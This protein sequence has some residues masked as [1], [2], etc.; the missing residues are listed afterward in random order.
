MNFIIHSDSNI[1]DSITILRDMVN[2][3]KAPYAKD[4][5]TFL[6]QINKLESTY[7]NCTIHIISDDSA[8]MSDYSKVLKTN[9]IDNILYNLFDKISKMINK[10]SSHGKQLIEKFKKIPK[11]NPNN[12]IQVESKKPH[13]CECCN[14]LME[15]NINTFVRTCNTCGNIED[16]DM[17]IEDH[18]FVVDTQDTTNNADILKEQGEKWLNRIQAREYFKMPIELDKALLREF[19]NQN[20]TDKREINY[21]KIRECLKNIREA[22]VYN[23]NIPSICKYYT[24]IAPEQLTNK[25]RTLIIDIFV[26]WCLLYINKFLPKDKSNV[27][28]NPY[29]L[30]RIIEIVLPSDDPIQRARKRNIL[31]YIHIQRETTTEANDLIFDK[32]AKIIPELN[33]RIQS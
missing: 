19:N 8:D 17:D 10:R 11:Y 9:N 20:I 21:K 27:P 32:I 18:D 12:H 5:E 1:M 29:I 2:Y 23:K 28:Y 13:T 33:S 3:I 24:R 15:I 31:S 30:S 22:S 6:E 7:R 16:N 4:K 14:S 26:E 25:E